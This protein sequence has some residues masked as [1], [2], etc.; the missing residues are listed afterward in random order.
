[1][2]TIAEAI[3]SDFKAALTVEPIFHAK[4]VEAVCTALSTGKKP[5]PEELMAAFSLVIEDSAHDQN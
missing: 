3:L 1:M 2:S 5:K 4:H